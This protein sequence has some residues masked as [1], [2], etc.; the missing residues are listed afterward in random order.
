M[1]KRGESKNIA[2]GRIEVFSNGHWKSICGIGF[3]T[4]ESQVA[5]KQLG[6]GFAKKGYSSYLHGELQSIYIQAF[7]ATVYV[8]WLERFVTYDLAPNK[9]ITENVP[10]VPWDERF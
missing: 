2:Q 8:N 5:C 9:H 6:L 3:T 4:R 7:I 1:N 10:N